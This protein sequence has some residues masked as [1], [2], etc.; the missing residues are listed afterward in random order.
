MFLFFV[1]PYRD[2]EPQK[3]F[4]SNYMTYLMEDLDVDVDYRVY[5]VEQC[6]ER[7]FNRG[8]LK[9]IGFLAASRLFPDDYLDFVFVFNDIDTVPYQKNMLTYASDRGTVRHHYGFR[10]A[11]GGIVSVTGHDF[12]AMNGFPNYWTWGF[13]D[14]ALQDR[15]DRLGIA[16][17]RSNFYG[18]GDMRIL[19]ITDGTD[20]VLNREYGN[21][22]I[23]D[24][25]ANG[26]STVRN[27]EYEVDGDTIKVKRFDAEYRV[28]HGSY[29][30][31]DIRNGREILIQRRKGAEPQK[32]AAE[33]GAAEQG[34]HKPGGHK[35]G[36]HKIGMVKPTRPPAEAGAPPVARSGFKWHHSTFQR[37]RPGIGRVVMRSNMA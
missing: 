31:Y 16:V 29:E 5:F 4:F 34:G 11:L 30:I 28:S 18:I 21:D 35:P 6:D 17:D 27:L 12:L 19:H 1:V 37:A 25:G 14:N 26:V 23:C 22:Y 10:H 15:A 20:K 9:N 13:E 8:A 3:F 7:P 33:K 2:R 36:G 32:G 24:T